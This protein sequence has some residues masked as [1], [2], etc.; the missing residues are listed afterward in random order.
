V[1][2]S[3]RNQ[4]ACA[5]PSGGIHL[6]DKLLGS[7]PVVTNARAEALLNKQGIGYEREPD[8]IEKGQKPDFYCRG[9]SNFW[10]EVKTLVQLPD[11]EE[12]NRALIQLRNRTEGISSPGYG[13]A[14]IRS[15]LSPRDAKATANL[16]K[17]AVPR[18]E[19]SD[20]PQVAIAM[21]P[22]DA[23]R[24]KFVRFPLSTKDHETVEFHCCEPLSGKYVIIR[25]MMPEPPDQ[26]TKL[27]FSSGSEKAVSA[28]DVVKAGEDF[29]VAVVVRLDDTPFEIIAVMTTGGAK[30]LDNPGRI[31][32]A[33][34]EAR[35][36]S[37][38]TRS[39]TK[40]RPAC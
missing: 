39:I 10:C 31:R 2:A 14:Y 21:I 13:I 27:R 18:L 38:R 19:A 23:M 26:I 29:R 9:R 6:S 1:V 12:R 4:L 16:L 28:E 30:Q 22:G 3:P 25:D 37:S 20:A 36:I 8:W 11:D 5:P 24:D 34:R 35:T 33:V 17:R 7:H 32:E 40:R 15:V